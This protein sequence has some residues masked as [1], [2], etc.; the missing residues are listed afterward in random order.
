MKGGGGVVP[1]NPKCES[2]E[3]FALSSL[4]GSLWKEKQCEPKS[5]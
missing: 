5:F 1:G 2:C 4:I 3:D